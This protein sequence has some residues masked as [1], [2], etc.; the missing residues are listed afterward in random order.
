MHQD[1]DLVRTLDVN[2]GRRRMLQPLAIGKNAL[3]G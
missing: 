1:A 3:P 2:I